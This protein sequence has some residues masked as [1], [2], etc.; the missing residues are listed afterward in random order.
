MKEKIKNAKW[1]P[2]AVALCIAVVLFVI[3][4]HLG[5]VL[6]AVKVFLG[7]FASILLG[8]VL[9]YLLNPLAK[10]YERKV[11][12]KVRKESLRWTL[13]I[14][15]TVLTL[16]LF[17]VLLLGTLIPQ[18]VDSITMLIEN[19]DDYLGSLQR[20]TDRLGISE[21]LKLDQLVDASGSIVNQV[22]SVL[23]DNIEAILTVSLS[24]GKGLIKWA[25]ALIMSIYMLAAKSSLKEGAKRLTHA[26]MPEKRYQNTIAFF[27][28][29][30]KILSQY[31]VYSL[32]DALI[33]GVANAIFM[34][35]VGMQYVGLVSLVVAVTNL[36]PT[37]GPIIGYVVG[38]FV[39]LLVNP[40]H[41][42][43]FLIFAFILQ[44]LDGYV[45]KPKLFGNSLGVSG[46][47]ILAA[48]IVF[49]NMFGIVGMLFAIPV[50]AILDFIYREAF[51]PALEKK[52]EK[53]S[54]GTKE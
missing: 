39:L 30:D 43:L 8:C 10:F 18:L 50:A 52:R 15:L 32:L 47:L 46:L 40:M 23:K 26:L 11:F 51:L 7:Y 17:L 25:I 49:G 29:C 22:M 4:T 5:P 27:T 45:I 44:F 16:V 13:S 38:G 42:L 28:R 24:A 21:M 14:V 1:Y 31:I 53:I 12:K 48:V 37:F 6:G 41:A 3:L 19:M 33:V 54:G 2:Y 34:A 35:C 9:A 20:M 36:I